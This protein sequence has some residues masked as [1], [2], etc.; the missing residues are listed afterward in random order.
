MFVAVSVIPVLRQ[1]STTLP[2][3]IQVQKV[4]HMQTAAMCMCDTLHW[5]HLLLRMF[6]EHCEF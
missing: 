2:T 6:L 3:F 4:F 1:Y 5:L